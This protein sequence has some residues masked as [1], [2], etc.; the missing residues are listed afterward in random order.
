MA[1]H[2]GTPVQRL[3][4]GI[5][6]GGTNTDAALVERA[7]NRVVASAKAPTTHHD[8]SL[9]VRSAI[10][11]TLDV[12][13]TPA[14]EVDLVALSTTL[15]TNALVEGA[16]R[17]AGLIAIG[18]SPADL[19]RAGVPDV[20]SQA[21]VVAVE[22]GHDTHG[23][24]SSPLDLDSIRSAAPALAN[25]VAA[26]AVT[27]RFAVR[28]TAHELAARDVLVELTGKP[29]T[30]SHELS[31]QLN[32]PKR[33]VT[34]LLNA[35]LVPVTTDLLDAVHEILAAT[36]ITAPL[37]VVRGDGSL[38]SAEEISR[39]P[40]ETILSGPAASLVGA[41]VLSGRRDALVVDVGGTT[42]DI[43]VLAGGQP[44]R[45]G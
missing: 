14:D 8:L 15:A 9:G 21:H 6:T 33:A 28:N 37:M 44:M 30:C 29:V 41:A 39:H 25:E 23:V 42:T 32:G 11:A 3:F 36:G 45:V 35:R 24:E 17:P 38:I 7:T 19:Q 4:L 22:G 27:S 20:V 2:A 10:E 43:A 5:D 1:E 13:R 34:A 12:A 26:F 16:G 40:V 31:A 18:F